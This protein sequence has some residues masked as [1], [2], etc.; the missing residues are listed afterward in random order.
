M[1]YDIFILVYQFLLSY[2]KT[3]YVQFKEELQ[4]HP[5]LPSLSCISD[6][7]NCHNLPHI[8]VRTSLEKLA[9]IGYPVLA[10]L[11]TKEFIIIE[12]IREG[13]VHFKSVSQGGKKLS[14]KEFEKQWSH[15]ALIPL[16]SPRRRISLASLFTRFRFSIAAH[17][18]GWKVF[19]WSVLAGVFFTV[20]LLTNAS[21]SFFL[22]AALNLLGLYIS[23][24]L[25]LQEHK[26]EAFSLRA[27]CRIGQYI[28]CNQ[29]TSS[30]YARIFDT[31]SWAEAG[32]AYFC[33]VLS[34]LALKPLLFNETAFY[35]YIGL[36][37]P[38]TLWSLIV[39]IFILRKF[40]L[41]CC[42]VI[43]LNWGNFLTFY[44]AFSGK[45]SF[46]LSYFLLLGAIFFI[47][48]LCIYL[49]TRNLTTLQKLDQIRQEHLLLKYNP[50][51]IGT[52]FHSPGIE[53]ETE[54]CCLPVHSGN[55]SLRIIFFISLFCRHCG[56]AI[57]RLRETIRQY[58][59]YSY[60][61]IYNIPGEAE[62]QSI[63]Q[64]FIQLQ[65]ALPEDSFLDNLEKWYNSEEKTIRYLQAK[66]PLSSFIDPVPL[67]NAMIHFNQK[68]PLA[69][70]PTLILNDHIFPAGYTAENLPG[71]LYVL[72]AEN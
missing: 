60:Q 22:L 30:P 55:A 69:Y 56:E 70:T 20:G 57:A 26:K 50:H 54:D 63:I 44:T 19:L 11:N 2:Q 28:D 68:Y 3:A 33:S 27:L 31:F 45:T 8:V 41:L 10:H 58:P 53:C 64:Y 13:W 35:L 47:G 29:V 32:M 42:S 59:Q 52:L 14:T 36:A 48:S 49:Y 65:S 38:F 51:I 6:L 1:Y 5:G 37:L 66:A 17:S 34:A 21:L 18:T 40:C 43:I 61:L 25:F 71:I 15:I 4:S 16:E 23:S 12:K 39:Q 24:E 7:L 67:F 46:S 9:S 72:E 62:A